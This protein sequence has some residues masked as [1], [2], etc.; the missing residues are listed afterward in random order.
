[1]FQIKVVERIKT[2]ILRTI[3]SFSESRTVYEIMW[4]NMVETDRSWQ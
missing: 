1:M 3:L 4:K 2:D